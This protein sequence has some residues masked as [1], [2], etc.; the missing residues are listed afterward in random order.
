MKKK[1]TVLFFMLV[2]LSLLPL[3]GCGLRSSVV[4]GVF[5]HDTWPKKRVLVIPARNLTAM[6]SEGVIDTVSE[7]ISTLLRE[8]GLFSVYRHDKTTQPSSLKPG[9]P[10]NPELT[11]SAR[12]MGMNAMI[13]E[14]VNP[15]ETNPVRSGIW[16]FRKN[17]RRYTI[18]MN[19][20]I[21]DVNTGTI[22]LNEDIAE[23]VT[24]PGGEFEVH[25]ENSHDRAEKQRALKQS[26]PD[27]IK[28]ASKAA[29]RSLIRLLWTSRVAFLDNEGVIVNAG[30]DAGLRPGIVLEVF[31]GNESMTSF[32]GQTYQ[33][34]G[35]KIGEIKI[36]SVRAR[37][38]T[39]TPIKGSDFKPDQIVRV[40]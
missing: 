17:A 32:N 27:I 14:T 36:I 1:P 34:P 3:G 30:R 15:I 22:I 16:P 18:S 12:A 20:E 39:A 31:G 5:P 4:P 19:I 40:K 8:T 21:V 13:L 25:N 26:L 38:S 23:I 37:H 7:E 35:P 10:I 33:L 9:E 28:S 24:L 29:Q 11:E 6:P 2:L